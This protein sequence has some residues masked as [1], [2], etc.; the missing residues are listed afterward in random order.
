MTN[1]SSI[2]DN[3]NMLVN[4][5][6]S[7]YVTSSRRAT[8]A[9]VDT[10]NSSPVMSYG[11]VVKD[12]FPNRHQ[13]LTAP[14]TII[15]E[16]EQSDSPDSAASSVDSSPK[17]EVLGDPGPKSCRPNGDGVDLLRMCGCGEPMFQLIIG[18]RGSEH[19]TRL[20]F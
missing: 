16:Q 19:P 13:Y 10:R 20:E 3:V 15:Q 9:A 1:S 2:Y 4:A 7:C 17:F 6:T 5:G 11:S 8:R 18:L 14:Q 12:V